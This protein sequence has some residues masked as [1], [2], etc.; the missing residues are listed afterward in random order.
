[1]STHEEEKPMLQGKQDGEKDDLSRRQFISDVAIKAAV[2]A[3]FGAVTFDSVMARAMDRVNEM[4]SIRGM[5]DDVAKGL[6][7]YAI[8]PQ[9]ICSQ[10][11]TC[12]STLVTCEIFGCGG[13][14]QHYDCYLR[15]LTCSQF[16]CDSFSCKAP[17]TD[18]GTFSC[19]PAVY[20]QPC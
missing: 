16:T 17:Y 13:G 10:N 14:G 15:D 11:Y 12:S 20:S 18:C 19:N 8:N 3:L 5:G 6:H 9:S 1:M 7:R 2:A 4:Q